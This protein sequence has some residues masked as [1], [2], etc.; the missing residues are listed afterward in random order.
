M[1]EKL[2]QEDIDIDGVFC[3]NNLVFLGAIKV[4]QKIGSKK[5]RNL[6]IAAFDIGR[7]FDFVRS[8][9]ISANQDLEKLAKSSVSILL[10]NI[11]NCSYRN[12]HFVLPVSIDKYNF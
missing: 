7:Y 3:V 8:P 9:I 10:N 1:M 12:T 6:K 2:L 4:M 5:N 11:G